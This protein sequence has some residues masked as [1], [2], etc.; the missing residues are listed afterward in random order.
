MIFLERSNCAF[1][2]KADLVT[3]CRASHTARDVYA[4]G[5]GIADAMYGCTTEKIANA[6]TTPTDA[7]K[8]AITNSFAFIESL[9]RGGVGRAEGGS[10]FKVLRPTREQE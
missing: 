7:S 10:R 8:P 5:V 4:F 3:K 9:K 1:E 2:G 6:A